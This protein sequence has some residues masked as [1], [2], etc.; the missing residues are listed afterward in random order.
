MMRL[1]RRSACP[2]P[3]VIRRT[4]LRQPD[5]RRGRRQTLGT[6]RR[7]AAE[8]QRGQPWPNNEIGA[9]VLLDGRKRVSPHEPL[10]PDREVVRI[11]PE[12]SAISTVPKRVTMITVSRTAHNDDGREALV[13]R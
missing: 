3:S 12:G 7:P 10:R 13:P 8:E 6:T 9:S 2:S 1:A 4:T 11:A 5:E